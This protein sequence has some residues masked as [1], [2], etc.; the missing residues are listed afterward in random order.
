MA[1]ATF[2]ENPLLL[3]VESPSVRNLIGAVLEKENYKVLLEEAEGAAEVLRRGAV[4]LL[5]TNEPWRFE[6]FLGRVRVLYIS[7]APDKDFLQSHWGVRF[8]YLQKPFRFQGLMD[9]VRGLVGAVR[10]S[11]H[12]AAPA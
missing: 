1:T 11:K 10:V 5:I 9:G 7:G 2:C 12:E 6:E 8:G 3:V 4:D